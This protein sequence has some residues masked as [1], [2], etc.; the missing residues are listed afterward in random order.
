MRMRAAA[1]MAA[2]RRA[3]LVSSR[4]D[5]HAENAESAT[6]RSGSAMKYARSFTLRAPW[7]SSASTI[8]WR[9]SGFCEAS[10]CGIRRESSREVSASSTA[11]MRRRSAGEVGNEPASTTPRTRP[12]GGRPTTG[13][14]LRAPRAARPRGAR[15][16]AAGFLASPGFLATTGFASG[17][18]A[19]GLAISS[20]FFASTRGLSPGAFEGAGLST[21]TA[22]M[23][24]TDINP[25]NTIFFIVFAFQL[26]G[27]PLTTSPTAFIITYF[28]VPSARRLVEDCGR[29]LCARTNN[30]CAGDL[31]GGG[32]LLVASRNQHDPAAALR[33][34]AH[35][36]S[37]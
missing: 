31:R 9:T 30:D 19:E 22:T 26:I 6:S 29:N 3:G 7:S 2:M 16:P 13:A 23:H 28:S 34:P 33:E 20:G 25:Q 5:V 17:C 18:T 10:T 24:M 32:A 21:P 27:S 35:G 11:S 14:P 15:A 8:A 1:R 4:T 12:R 36:G 37:V